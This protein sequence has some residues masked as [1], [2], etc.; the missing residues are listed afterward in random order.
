MPAG[1]PV[2]LPSNTSNRPDPCGCPAQCCLR[3][4]AQNIMVQ[5]RERRSGNSRRLRGC[6]LG[7]IGFPLSLLRQELEVRHTVFRRRLRHQGHPWRAWIPQDLIR[8]W[9]TIEMRGWRAKA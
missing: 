9:V 1:S 5:L 2:I 8:I 3:W 6:V 4:L 7:L